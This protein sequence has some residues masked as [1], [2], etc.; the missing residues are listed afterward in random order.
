MKLTVANIVTYVGIAVLLIYVVM[1]IMN[2]Y[3]ISSESYNIYIIFYVFLLFSVL[4][5][6]NNS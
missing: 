1:G 5:F 4:L 3:G 6:N 2:F